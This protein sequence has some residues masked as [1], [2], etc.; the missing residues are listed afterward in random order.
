MHWSD[1]VPANLSALMR[2][3]LVVDGT[4]TKI[5]EAYFLE[6]VDV[7]VLSQSVEI[8]ARPDR[9][10]DAD[11]GESV[12]DR[13]V[14]LAGGQTGRMYTYAESKIVVNRLS[15]RM[16]GRL[17]DESFGLGRILL[18]GEVE[19]R[20]E[21]LWFGRQRLED[22]PGPVA[23]HGNGEFVCRTYRIIGGGRPLMSITEHFPL[24]LGC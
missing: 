10:L 7:R 18:D 12:V 8:L 4:V 2:A 13:A 3:L 23:A 11:A 5:L 24:D 22:P 15:G 9:W 21:C 16:Q 20:R 1:V 19:T 17:D 6:P 14:V